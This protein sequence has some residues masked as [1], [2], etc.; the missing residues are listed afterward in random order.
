MSLRKRHAKI[1]GSGDHD[2]TVLQ[3]A[4]LGAQ[5]NQFLK[6]EGKVVVGPTAAG[7]VPY[8]VT[9]TTAFPTACDGVIVILGDQQ[10]WGLPAEYETGGI[11]I[12]AKSAAGFTLIIS[13]TVAPASPM[14]INFMVFAVGH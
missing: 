6:I 3:T 5:N 11:S 7:D 9:F 2:S 12:S 10:N 8:A 13:Y 4:L 14:N 1:H